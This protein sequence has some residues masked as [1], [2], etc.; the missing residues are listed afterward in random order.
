[1]SFDSRKET[2]QPVVEHG[3]AGKIMGKKEDAGTF[4]YCPVAAFFPGI[5]ETEGT[6]DE[7]TPRNRPAMSHGPFGKQKQIGSG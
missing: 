3:E 6:S 2:F 1:V 5:Q 7:D 4:L